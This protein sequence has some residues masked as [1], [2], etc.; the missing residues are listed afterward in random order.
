MVSIFV[1]MFSCIFQI[2]YIEHEFLPQP[3]K[4]FLKCSFYCPVWK[5]KKKNYDE[6]CKSLPLITQ[7][8]KI[9]HFL[10]LIF[11]NSGKQKLSLKNVG[12]QFLCLLTLY[13]FINVSTGSFN[14]GELVTHESNFKDVKEIAH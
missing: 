12:A 10:A 11:A 7:K 8:L 2:F 1:F 3:R 4:T 5:K 9:Y 6:Q 14:L 13:Q